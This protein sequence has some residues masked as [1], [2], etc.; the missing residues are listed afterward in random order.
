MRPGDSAIRPIDGCLSERGGHL[1]VEECDTV[2]LAER[3]G[4]PLFVL[5]ET[6][7]R[8][9]VRRFHEAFSRH[10]GEGPVQVLPALKANWTLAT[11]RI[12]S[13]EG[14]GAD[15]YSEGELHGALEAG[16]EPGKISVNGGGKSEAMIR[17]CVEAGV[18][19]TVEDL[20]E[21]ELIERVSRA[22][23]RRAQVRLRVKPSFPRLW[24]PTDFA[25]EYAPIDLGIQVYKSGIPAEYL[26]ELGRKVLA[27]EH[28]ELVGAHF[29]AGRHHRS[30]WFWRGLMREY[31]RLL[32]ELSRAWG[33][34]R[35]RE[36]DIGGGFASPRDPFGRL[37]L[38]AETVGTWFS[39]PFEVLL[40]W[41]SPRLHYRAASALV[42]A[43]SH[44]LSRSR[45]PSV[46]QYAEASAGALREGLRGGGLDPAG[47]ALQLEPGR[48]LYGD[49]G[50][51]LTRVKKVKRQSKPLPLSWVLTDT[52]YF[53]LSGG[54]LE[55]NFHDYRVANKAD[56]PATMTAD[57][58]GHSCFADRILPFARLPEVEAGDLVALLD[59]GAYQEVS[60][61]NFNALPRPASVLVCGAQAEVIRRAETLQDVYARDVVP[62]RLLQHARGPG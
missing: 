49:T 15:V 38:R 31:G 6:Q 39:Y 57:V 55:N 27:L 13:E 59:T 35:P 29:H 23:G 10:W 20:D 60:A 2:E 52:T 41:L 24:R 28:L 22:L 43:M 62:E 56:R 47:I 11:R 14:A 50:L 45:A 46:E 33:G 30:L 4:T 18:R 54:V 21:P 3:F 40:N 42:R 9:N 16:V 36:I 58:V 5:S 48:S 51:H 61:S 8:G 37:G 19:I 25:L 34:W 12:L 32:A 26:P 7:L 53:F 17:R 44:G 1:Y